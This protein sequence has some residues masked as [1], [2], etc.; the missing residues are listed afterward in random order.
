M[1]IK[2]LS[3]LLLLAVTFFALNS[4]S[5]DEPK[6]PIYTDYEYSVEIS[7]GYSMIYTFTCTYTDICTNETYTKPVGNLG[8]SIFFGNCVGMGKAKDVV[9]KVEG[10]LKD[11]AKEIVEDAIAKHKS[12]TVGCR[13][14]A[15]S[16]TY[17]DEAKTKPAKNL[18]TFAEN[19]ESTI[20]AEGLKYY[21]D[22]EP[23]IVLF[24]KHFTIK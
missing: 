19:F 14:S 16:S 10:T 7:E 3:L 18:L 1:K 23:T 21:L 12:V 9:F 2:Q 17:M 5:N 24:E 6:S 8:P 11:N 4:C 22:N 15:M 13:Y 20:S